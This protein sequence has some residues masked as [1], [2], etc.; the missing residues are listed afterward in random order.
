MST[1]TGRVEAAEGEVVGEVELL[2]SG[3]S[4]ALLERAFAS[5][6]GG[7]FLYIAGS[8]LGRLKVRYVPDDA[9]I[10][11]TDG[12]SLIVGRA[13]SRFKEAVESRDPERWKQLKYAI[14][15][16]EVA[17]VLYGHAYRARLV[18]DPELYNIVADLLANTVV[19]EKLKVRVPPEFV[20]AKSLPAF[21]EEK[22][23]VS[24]PEEKKRA[25]REAGARFLRGELSTEDVYRL[26]ESLGEQAVNRVKQHFRKSLFFGRDLV[27]EAGRRLAQPQA[28]EEAGGGGAEPAGETLKPGELSE[29]GEV[30]WRAVREAGEKLGRLLE[31]ERR[32][33]GEFKALKYGFEGSRTAGTMPGVVGEAEYRRMR[34]LTAPIETSFLREVGESVADY[35]V[36][37]SRHDDDAYWL[38][39]HEEVRRSRVLLLLDSSPS[40]SEDE[41]ALFMNL[42]RRALEAYDIEY[43]VSV[44]SVGEVDY[45]VLAR[46]NFDEKAFKVKRGHGTVWDETVAERIRRASLA[47]VRLVQV[48]SDFAVHVNPEVAEEVKAFKARGGRISCYSVTGEFAPFC[49]FKHYIKLG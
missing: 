28:G 23:G 35:E 21:L 30:L 17:H 45:A 27:D 47:G 42:A 15:L 44:F 31:E 37:F 29:R 40:I 11:A 33:L 1:R 34:A 4:H 5:R 48:L 22:L 2:K 25:V 19:E 39:A 14:L 49:D 10:M 38:P 13:Y 36:T 18:R 26:F 7:E 12:E 43:E 20:T 8:V 41:L 24:L 6:E 9:V 46:D 16:H 3:A 32:A